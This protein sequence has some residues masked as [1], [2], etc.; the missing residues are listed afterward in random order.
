MSKKKRIRSI[1]RQFTMIFIG[2]MTG[3]ILLCWFLNITFLEDFYISDKQ[4]TL[5]NAYNTINSAAKQGTLN[6]EEFNL[7]LQGLSSRY[8][9]D[10]LVWMW[11]LKQ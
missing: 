3:T 5:L 2:L 1:S 4:E 6:T 11:I 10:V 8:N 9:M 7:Q